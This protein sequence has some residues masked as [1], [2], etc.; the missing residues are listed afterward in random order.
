MDIVLFVDNEL[1]DVELKMSKSLK[2][3]YWNTC[4]TNQDAITSKYSTISA[5]PTLK[6][7]SAI[8]VIQILF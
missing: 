6:A 1:L 2:A 3:Y 8:K 7:N 5:K 4:E